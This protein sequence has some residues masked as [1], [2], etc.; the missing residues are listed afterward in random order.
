MYPSR[1]LAAAHKKIVVPI[2]LH[3]MAAVIGEEL[4]VKPATRVAIQCPVNGMPY[5][6]VSLKSL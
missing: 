4:F 2:D 5:P 3:E 6:V 1:I